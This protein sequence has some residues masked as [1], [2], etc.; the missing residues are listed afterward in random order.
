[1]KQVKSVNLH[2]GHES[3]AFKKKKKKEQK[4]LCDALFFLSCIKQKQ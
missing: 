1:M 3:N 2:Q 4:I